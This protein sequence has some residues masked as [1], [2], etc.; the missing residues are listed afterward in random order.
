MSIAGPAKLRMSV[1]GYITADM[2]MVVIV[3]WA[4]F[5]LMWMG[6]LSPGRAGAIA[7]RSIRMKITREPPRQWR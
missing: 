5:P 1:T 2:R 3:A 7:A 4:L 6:L